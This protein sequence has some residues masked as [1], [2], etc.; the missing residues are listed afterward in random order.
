MKFREPTKLHRKSGI[1]GTHDS[2]EG[3]RAESEIESCTAT[4]A[5][6]QG[7]NNL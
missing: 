3:K 4:K 7:R 6:P 5:V 1:W 2:L